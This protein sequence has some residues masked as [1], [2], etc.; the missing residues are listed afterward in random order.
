MTIQSLI[1][2]SIGFIRRHALPAL[3]V[4]F[5]TA[6]VAS[7]QVRDALIVVLAASGVWVFVANMFTYS[8]TPLDLT[9]EENKHALGHIALGAAILVSVVIMGVV[10]VFYAP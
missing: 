4:I 3:Y 1:T 8:F 5:G 7:V 6:A 2:Q 10:Y 9:K